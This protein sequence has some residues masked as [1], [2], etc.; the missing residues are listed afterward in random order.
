[1]STRASAAE[2]FGVSQSSFPSA[3]PESGLRISAPPRSDGPLTI[4]LTV[5]EAIAGLL[6]ERSFRR[7]A[8]TLL[9]E[10]SSRHLGDAR[11]AQTVEEFERGL[12]T[13]MLSALLERT[14]KGVTYQGAEF[15]ATG[16]ASLFVSNHR[17]I[18]LDSA[19]LSRLVLSLGRPAPHPAVGDNLLHNGWIRNFFRLVDCFVIRRNLKG[20]ELYMHSRQVSEYVRG[21]LDNGESVWIAQRQGRTRDGADRT[22]P[23]LLRMLLMAYE[24]GHDHAGPV[25]PVAPV[26]VSYEYEPC[27]VFKA[28]CIL[29][30]QVR[31][32]P[33]E[34]GR[35][36][37]AHMLGGLLQPKG[38]IYLTVREPVMVDHAAA[39][40]RGSDRAD[41]IADLAARVDLEIARGYHIW[42][43]NYV[44]HDLASGKRAYADHY[45]PQEREEFCAYLAHSAERIL[46]T[47]EMA[48]HALLKLYARAVDQRVAL[49]N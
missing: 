16:S 38:R 39:K 31:H 1:M 49:T 21:L 8:R 23:A 30:A 37:T 15:L 29:N 40:G 19:L 13:L 17:D 5:P 20:K 10:H 48:E 18:L 45:T 28:A 22:E 36:D 35:R 9:G 7:L 26:A 44:A 11:C 33:L 46:A 24:R 43:T 14:S 3:P 12:G 27:D 6:Q 32:S 47:R 25:L 42:P 34:R 4:D 41:F 2:I